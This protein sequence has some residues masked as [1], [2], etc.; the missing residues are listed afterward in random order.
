MYDATL[1]TACTGLVVVCASLLPYI[2]QSTHPNDGG[3][4]HALQVPMTHRPQHQVAPHMGAPGLSRAEMKKDFDA[5]AYAGVL[6]GYGDIKSIFTTA[7]M[8][9]GETSQGLHAEL[10]ELAR[11]G[12]CSHIPI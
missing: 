11:T 1:H 6:V 5:R 10:E 3:I 12:R 8:L 7:H 2:E 4:P 9:F